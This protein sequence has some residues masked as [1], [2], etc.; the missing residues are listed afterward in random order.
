MQFELKRY[1]RDI[2]NEE[3]IEDLKRVANHLGKKTLTT[4]EYNQSKI[5]KYAAGTIARRF[6]NWNNA[7]E[8][9]E[10]LTVFHHD[11]SDQELLDDLI[12]VS[13]IIAPKKLTQDIYSKIGK[14]S[15]NT[16]NTR[17]GWNK[18]LKKLGLEIS[19]E[20]CISEEDLFKNMEEVWI[21]IGKQPGRRDMIKTVSNYSERPYIT[22]FGSWQNALEAFVN[23]INQEEKDIKQTEEN[24][25]HKTNGGTQQ[26]TT[27]F[28]KT[29]RDINLRL[30][31]L[32]MRRDNFKCVICG[33][34]P[35]TDPK[36]ILHVDHI[37]SWEKGGETLFENLQT[38]CSDDNLGKSNLDMYSTQ[39]DINKMPKR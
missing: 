20:I 31:F 16:I 37:V 5:K 25:D 39:G 32:V 12:K 8:K 21:K 14:F 19:N 24:L 18:A 15:S 36:I 11:I 17:F 30:R 35:A 23:Y 29:K 10:L 13:K 4:D 26:R 9:A 1:N 3:L 28:H 33:R 6:K 27:N 7:L 34:S 2:P 22:K 38:L